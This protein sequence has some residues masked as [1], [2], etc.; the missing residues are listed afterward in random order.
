MFL[1][2]GLFEVTGLIPSLAELISLPTFSHHPKLK[3][4]CRLCHPEASSVTRQKTSTWAHGWWGRC[5]WLDLY[6]TLPIT[7][8]PCGLSGFILKHENANQQIWLR[9]EGSEI[10]FV[11]REYFCT[12]R[13]SVDWSG[14]ALTQPWSNGKQEQVAEVP[15]Q[16]IFYEQN[17]QERD[18][19]QASW[20]GQL[21]SP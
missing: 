19:I 1:S 13:V 4:I 12:V 3:R 9:K 8:L 16:N 2:S 11:K 15:K 7:Q 5:P 20:T 17:D 18:F 10:Y 21:V 6:E 14:Q